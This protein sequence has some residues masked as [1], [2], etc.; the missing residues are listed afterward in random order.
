[1]CV[2]MYAINQIKNQS[3]QSNQCTV[4]KLDCIS[5][6]LILS[7]ETTVGYV[8]HDPNFFLCVCIVDAPP[9]P[10]THPPPLGTKL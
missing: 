6:F 9:P 1:M 5:V 7:I 8:T 2:Y 10:P 4:L 3:N